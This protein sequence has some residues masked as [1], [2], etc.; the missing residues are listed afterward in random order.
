[1]TLGVA[2]ASVSV[3]AVQV[4]FMRALSVVQD[5]HF[6]YFVISI[7]LLGFGAGGT[8]LAVASRSRFRPSTQGILLAYVAF[9]SLTPVCLHLSLRIPIDFQYLVFDLGQIGNLAIFAALAFVPFFTGGLVVGSVLARYGAVGDILYGGNLVGSGIG[10]VFVLGLMVFV[11]PTRLFAVAHLVAAFGVLALIVARFRV[12]GSRWSTVAASAAAIGAAVAG[13]IVSPEVAVDQ[14][15]AL[16]RLTL[17]ED[18]G[19]AE[20]VHSSFSPQGRIDVFESRTF[21]YSPFASPIPEAEP[22]AQLTLLLDGSAAGSILEIDRTDETR[23]FEALPQ[24][25]A[26]AL[27]KPRRVLLLGETGGAA[28]WL[29]R[30]FG[31]REITVVQPNRAL[32]DLLEGELAVA[33]GGVYEGVELIA[34]DP[35]LFL[36]STDREFDLIHAVS[37]ETLPGIGSGLH[38]LS[39][40]YLMT[41]EGVAAMLDAASPAGIVTFTRGTQTPPRDNIK[42][43]ATA[44]AAV[45]RRGGNPADTL[46]Q[47]RNYLAAT[48][49]VSESGFAPRFA[50]A[51]ESVA[52]ELVMDI[53]YAPG[54]PAPEEQ[55]NHVDGPPGKP[56]SY[57]YAANRAIVAGDQDEFFDSWVYRVGPATD[58][59]PYFENFFRWRTLRRFRATYGATWIRRVELGYLVLVVTL[60]VCL[61]LS[62][63]MIGAPLAIGR[64]S[65]LRSQAA[66]GRSSAAGRG[67]TIGY[68]ATIGV[69]FMFVEIV[70]IQTFSQALGNHVYSATAVLAGMLVFSGI[71]SVTQTRTGMAD[72]RRIRVGSVVAFGLIVVFVL[73]RRAVMA[74]AAVLGT[75]GRFFLVLVVLMPVAYLLGWFFSSGIRIVSRRSAHLVPWAWAANGF[76]SVLASPL[77]LLLAMELGHSAVMGIA[78]LLYLSLYRYGRR[79]DARHRIARHRG[80][81]HLRRTAERPT[82]RLRKE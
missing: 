68:F 59:R 77:A 72:G 44:A 34:G 30:Y 22:P 65:R 70:A 63:V 40:N 2:A 54:M 15:K 67:A 28:V 80:P 49:L 3:I 1:M 52:E 43:F 66:R 25:I 47:A 45:R 46:V 73:A 50:Q 36:E 78:A 74:Y 26:Y 53:E 71:G 56:Y 17:L 75:A 82:L 64:P 41:V 76:A 13:A 8:A 39:E 81:R 24:S 42:I 35:R 5:F 4:G 16:S 79:W 37:M 21:H 31:A 33:A 14:H 69:G 60:A 38:S 55:L 19:A 12:S 29:A 62:V 27:A 18:Q 20:R 11:P 61:V 51:L 7:A 23:M 32:L 10:A 57:H 6:S 58:E 48:T 9:L